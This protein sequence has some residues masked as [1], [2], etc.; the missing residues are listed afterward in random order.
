MGRM[1]QGGPR[2]SRCHDM[3]LGTGKERTRALRLAIAVLLVLL[4]GS[5]LT[6]CR[7]AEQA[8]VAELV[9]QTRARNGRSALRDNLQLNEKAQAWAER[10]AADNRLAHS[11]L[12]SGITYDWR[13]LAENVGYGGSIEQV[14][15]AYMNSPGHRANILDPRWNY[16]GTGVAWRGNRVFTVQVFMQY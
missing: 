11:D 1:T 12:P 15:E 10:L 16:M 4:M 14:H 8:R 2:I 13:A 3:E 6:S 7:S 5:T 9:N